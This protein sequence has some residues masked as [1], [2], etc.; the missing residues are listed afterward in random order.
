MLASLSAAH[1]TRVS[2]GHARLNG[3]LGPETQFI[4]HT[5]AVLQLWPT[6]CLVEADEGTYAVARALPPRPPQDS[7]ARQQVLIIGQIA[8][9]LLVAL[10][11]GLPAHQLAVQCHREGGEDE[12]GEEGQ[13]WGATWGLHP[14]GSLQ[15]TLVCTDFAKSAFVHIY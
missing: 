6:G 5:V 4:L 7:F 3:F 15:L 1:S 11:Q 14:G 12:E 8:I 10:E 9:S 13:R 2:P